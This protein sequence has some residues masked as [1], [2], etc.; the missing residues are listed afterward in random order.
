MSNLTKFTIL[1]IV[2]FCLLILSLVTKLGIATNFVLLVTLISYIM[3]WVSLD[4]K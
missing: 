4:L 3:I 1:F 2:M